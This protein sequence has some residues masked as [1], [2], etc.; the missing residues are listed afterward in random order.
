M[1]KKVFYMNGYS[2]PGILLRS[3]KI[4]FQIV[5]GGKDSRGENSYIS[6]VVSCLRK[7][8]NAMLEYQIEVEESLSSLPTRHRYYIS[9]DNSHND[10]VLT[11]TIARNY[12]HSFCENKPKTLV[13]YD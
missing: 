2:I 10:D 8:I 12:R 13:F 11:K 1:N 7:I 9:Y 5:I 6:C 4:P 3:A